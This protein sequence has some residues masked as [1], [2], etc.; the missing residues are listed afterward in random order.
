MNKILLLGA[1]SGIGSAYTRRLASAGHDLLLCGRSTHELEQLAQDMI[2]QFSVDIRTC[3]LD[4]T[5]PED[6]L[7]F[8]KKYGGTIDDVFVAIGF[9]APEGDRSAEALVTTIQA[10]YLGIATMLELAATDF[11]KRGSGSIICISSVAGERGRKSNYW[12]G[13]AK[14]GLTAFLA[15]L[16][17]RLHGHGVHVAT[18][19]AGYVRT[20][21]IAHLKTPPLLT[22]TPEEVANVIYRKAYLQRRDVIYVKSIW[23]PIMFIIRHLPAFIFKRLDL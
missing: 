7:P 16:R 17:H 20:K 23:R 14:A 22:A 21:M 3:L 18:I 8:W 5:R 13:S 1:T 9:L 6:Q 11:A 10:N 4:I 15:G 19:K 12:Y 2:K